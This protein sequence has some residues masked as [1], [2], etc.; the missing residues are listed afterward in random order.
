[1]VGIFTYNK[2]SS[3]YTYSL[4]IKLQKIFMPKKFNCK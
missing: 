3:I 2:L 4:S 1:M